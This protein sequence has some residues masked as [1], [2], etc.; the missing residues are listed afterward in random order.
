VVLKHRKVRKG[1]K[2]SNGAWGAEVS[3]GREV[4]GNRWEVGMGQVNKACSLFYGR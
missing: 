1:R 4:G 3:G 2:E